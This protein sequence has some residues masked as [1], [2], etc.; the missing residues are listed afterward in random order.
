MIKFQPA[1]EEPLGLIEGQVP[2]SKEEWWAALALW[3]Y[4]VQ[5]MYQFQIFGGVSRR[6]GLIVDFVVWNPMATPF[7]V[8]GNYW[9]R[10]EMDGGDETSLIAIEQHFKREAIILWGYDAQT[11][12]DVDEFVRE[13]VAK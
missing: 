10:N 4:E 2:D 3:K 1:E 12:E 5:F 13:N 9:H 8:H 7:L 6:G 11:K